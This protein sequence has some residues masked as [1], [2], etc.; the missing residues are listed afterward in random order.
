[1]EGVNSQDSDSG[2]HLSLKKMRRLGVKLVSS[3]RAP[4]VRQDL[5][6]TIH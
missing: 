1:M 3:Y 4:G 2:C 6:E 5:P